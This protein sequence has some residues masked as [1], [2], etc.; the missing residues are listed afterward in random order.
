MIMTL[1]WGHLC[2]ECLVVP[3]GHCLWPPS[4]VRNVSW[5]PMGLAHQLKSAQISPDQPRSAQISPDQLRSAQISSD[6]PSTFVRNVSWFP[7]GLA[8]L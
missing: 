1:C 5:F 3:D 6:Q 8:L 2:E 7:M 4:F